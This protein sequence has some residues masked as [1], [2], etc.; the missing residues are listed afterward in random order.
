MDFG[1]WV[2]V[3]LFVVE[4]S[5]LLGDIGVIVNDDFFG[6]IPLGNFTVI[7]YQTSEGSQTCSVPRLSGLRIFVGA[8]GIHPHFKPCC[9]S[10]STTSPKGHEVV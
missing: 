7:V 1:C 6:I 3:M 9:H 10:S 2:M 5:M 8:R 4:T